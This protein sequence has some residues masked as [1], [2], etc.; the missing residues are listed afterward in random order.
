MTTA[1]VSTHDDAVAAAKWAGF[2][3]AQPLSQLVAGRS[4][5]QEALSDLPHPHAV[6]A[7][8]ADLLSA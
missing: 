2:L 5:A 4:G 8:A 1:F 3:S 7:A 6:A